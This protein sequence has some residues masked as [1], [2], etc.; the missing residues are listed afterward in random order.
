MT[1]RLFTR[2][3][4]VVAGVLLALVA[5][6]LIFVPGVAEAVAF[7][8]HPTTTVTAHFTRAVGLYPG[9]QVRVLGV[10][11]GTV[12]SVTPEGATVRVVLDVDADQKVP[13]D[14][15][16]AVMSPSLVSDR[17]VQL[18]PVWTGGP[19]M[20]A[21]TLANASSASAAPASG[22]TGRSCAWASPRAALARTSPASSAG[23]L[24]RE[25]SSLAMRA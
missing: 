13:A 20:A 19:A 25:N 5:A 12:R 10:P 18:L 6:A 9:S 3:A 1:A 11:V 2:Q 21:G 24:R 7:W 17:Y 16:A 14:A 22:S 23:T 15:K 4:T 8:R